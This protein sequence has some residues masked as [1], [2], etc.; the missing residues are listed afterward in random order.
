MLLWPIDNSW[1][2]EI[3]FAQ[4][5]GDQRDRVYASLHAIGGWQADRS[6]AG[7][8]SEWHTAGVEWTPSR[9]GYTLDGKVW[10]TVRD[11]RVPDEPMALAL[12]TQAWYCGHSWQRCPDSTTP[13]QVDLQVD[14]VVA[15]SRRSV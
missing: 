6:K 15:Y 1:P 7:N 3:D 4:D 5:N 10:G 2:P 13:T 9:I 12:Q 8:F 11:S 14:W